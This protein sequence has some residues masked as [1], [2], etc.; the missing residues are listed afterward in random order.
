MAITTFRI[1][2][3][4]NIDRAVLCCGRENTQWLSKTNNDNVWRNLAPST[5][6]HKGPPTTDTAPPRRQLLQLHRTLKDPS[7]PAKKAAHITT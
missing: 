1:A 6:F 2:L 3:H 4:R 5:P 7:M